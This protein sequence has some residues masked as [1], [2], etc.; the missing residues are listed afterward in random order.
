M[1]YKAALAGEG[2]Q[3]QF[4]MSTECTRAE[5]QQAVS[6]HRS[7]IIFDAAKEV[8]QEHGLEG[9]S[10]RKI[11][12][13]AGYTPGAIYFYYRS[14]EEIY[15]ALLAESL[16]RLN[17]AVAASGSQATS[18]REKLIASALGLFTFYANNPRDLDLG[19]YLFNGMKPHGLT[20][21][22]NSRLNRR[23]RDA[24]ALTEGVLLEIGASPQQA[25][26]EITALFGHC[27]GLLLLQH[28]GRMKV[29]KQNAFDLFR[30][31]A[32]Q[33]SQR[34]GDQKC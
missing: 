5:R 18:L 27:T 24:L 1:K 30:D 19:F 3:W 32:E 23:L 20:P 15:G 10:M 31:Y 28:T 16:E 25:G 14:K 34:Y 21:E 29:F 13:R 2:K 6:D 12:S 9:A 4:F 17:Q 11:A 33:L 22:L 26:R 7:A 8:F